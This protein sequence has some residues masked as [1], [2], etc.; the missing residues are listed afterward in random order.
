MNKEERLFQ[1]L[2]D[3]IQQGIDSG[4]SPLSTEDI[5]MSVLK[6]TSPRK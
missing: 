1:E 4:I 2:R 6:P 5:V 3:E